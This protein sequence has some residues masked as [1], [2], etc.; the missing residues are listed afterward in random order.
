MKGFKDIEGTEI[1]QGDEIL[2]T[3]PGWKNASHLTRAR[4]VR[5]TSATMFIKGVKYFGGISK[6]R[7]F[8]TK[9]NQGQTEFRALV[10]KGEFKEYSKTKDLTNE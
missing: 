8:E 2:V 6:P 3:V 9:I 5:F 10:I 1:C 4:V 7:S